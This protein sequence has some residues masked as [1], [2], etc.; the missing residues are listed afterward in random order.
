M[1][2]EICKKTGELKTY[3]G[4]LIMI[5]SL[6]DI[7]DEEIEKPKS[8]TLSNPPSDYHDSYLRKRNRK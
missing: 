4:E 8:R 6:K 1:L 2:M 3:Q 5:V 7:D